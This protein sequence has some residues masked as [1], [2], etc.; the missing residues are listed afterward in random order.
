MTMTILT[1]KG[2][3]ILVD[4][5]DYAALSMHSWHVTTSGYAMRHKEVCGKR[6][7][8]WMHRV[9][10]GLPPEDAR[11][12]DHRNGNKLDNRRLN[13]RISTETQNNRN[14]RRAK[15][16]T[17]GYKGVHWEGR[18]NRWRAQIQARGTRKNLGYFHTA[19]QAHE[20]YCL[21][22]DLL[23]GEFANYG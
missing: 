18:R 8:I 12:P 3:S 7:K 21:A 14:A 2:Q 15:T 9:I 5:E 23:F 13:L 11:M 10:A 22:A 4:D 20:F 16:N 19:E 1:A 17:S 6:Q